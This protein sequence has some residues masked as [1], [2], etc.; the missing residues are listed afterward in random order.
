[1]TKVTG[2]KASALWTEYLDEMEKTPSALANKDYEL[3]EKHNINAEQ[4][5]NKLTVAI[6]AQEKELEELRKP[7][8]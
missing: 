6:E 8:I 1:M 3:T 5:G 2:L 4:L 7:V